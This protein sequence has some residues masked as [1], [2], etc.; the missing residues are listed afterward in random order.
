MNR[1][2]RRLEGL[3]HDA[4]AAGLHRVYDQ[5]RQ[6]KRK[7]PIVLGVPE[8][9]VRAVGRIVRSE[10]DAQFTVAFTE[11]PV[12]SG[13]ERTELDRLVPGKLERRGWRAALFEIGRRRDEHAAGDARPARDQRRVRQVP[14]A[15]GEIDAVLDEADHAVR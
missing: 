13:R 4:Q 2:R 5:I 10:W 15:H 14:D 1:Q 9:G 3:E 8:R 7:P 11:R 6:C 12:G